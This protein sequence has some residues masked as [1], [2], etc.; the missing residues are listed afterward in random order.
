MGTIGKPT[1]E[2]LKEAAEELTSVLD[3]MA[4]DPAADEDQYQALL[5]VEEKLTILCSRL[6]KPITQQ[7]TETTAEVAGYG[8]NEVFG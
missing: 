6:M 5:K 4:I 3:L 1:V 7:I 8:I 2:I